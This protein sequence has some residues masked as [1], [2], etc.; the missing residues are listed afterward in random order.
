MDARPDFSEGPSCGT[1]SPVNSRSTALRWWI[2]LTLLLLLAFGVRVW[3]LS[4]VPPGLTHDEASNGHDSAA[5]LHGVHRIY[6][7][8]GY[9][10][11]PLYNYSVALTTLL[12][13]QRIFTLRLTTVFWGMA[14]CVLTM[15][16]ARRWW[17]RAGAVAVC[18]IYAASFWSLMLARV[19][20]RAPALP[21]LL[22]GSVLAYD[23]A[24][25]GAK[26]TSR[27]RTTGRHAPRW[28]AYLI[29]GGLLGASFY[30]YM[31]SRGMPLLYATFLI[32]VALLNRARARAIWRGTLGVL[33]VALLIGAPLFLYLHAHPE[34]EQRIGQLGHALTALRAGD[35]RPLWRN[36]SD[37]LPLLIWRG[38]PYWLYNVAGRPGLEPPL[39]AV[40]VIGLVVALLRLKDERHL[41][42]LIWLV[43]GLA[44]ALIAP[45]E[46]N[47]LH[48]IAAMPAAFLIAA[49]GLL[50]LRNG[51]L[52]LWPRQRRPV[53]LG[54]GAA[55]LI[56]LLLTVRSTARA[57]FVT[58]AGNR[59]VRVAYHH[60]VVA[61]SRYLDERMDSRP[62]VITTLYPGKHHDPYTVEVV[63]KRED[64]TLRWVDG[65]GGLAV[66]AS[67]ARLF[68]ES[69]TQ[70]PDVLWETVGP[71][72][73]PLVEL[74]FRDD[75]IP[76]EIQGYVWDAP[77][78][79]KR[80]AN[81]AQTEL[82]VQTGDPPPGAAHAATNAPITYGDAATLVGYRWLPES[83]SAPPITQHLLTLWQVSD[84]IEE[85]LVIFAHLL[86]GQ[87]VFITQD[88]R[89]D[90]PTWQW[91]AGDRF[92]QL[93]EL[94]LP[95]ETAPG[96]YYVAL[97]L[98]TRD[99]VNR[100]PIQT[101]TS[102]PVGPLTRGLIP[103][104]VAAP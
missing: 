6:F 79:W 91:R 97:G 53:S 54:L 49:R 70:P 38:D 5:I 21:T 42:V 90:T 27:R 18:A 98:Y 77:A 9:G 88:D 58:W 39:A 55:G 40:F 46:Y 64:L 3:Q 2:L 74:A 62:A 28:A 95:S 34:L 29:S 80:L 103:L 30:T 104:E 11:E 99:D 78:T 66:P 93:H 87:G 14:Q 45:V 20:L 1:I 32:A 37:S 89:L 17:G 94:T 26:G 50:C 68:V 22:V 69:Q 35:W 7:P 101:S 8:V 100:L 4:H 48:A 23:H 44:P 67:E 65:R 85:E 31:A 92:L 72:V 86:D 61:L 12:L 19:G 10:H 59:N 60:H 51:V 25:A 81:G 84:G 71:D 57:Y 33:L 16:L 96:R 75:D 73:A 43:G 52:A 76:S 56:V 82:W 102:L 63:M 13:G 41:L 83:P 24:I 36:I 47:L 15:A